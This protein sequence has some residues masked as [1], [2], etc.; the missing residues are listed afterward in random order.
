MSS[1][2]NEIVGEIELND[3]RLNDRLVTLVETFVEHPAASI[4]E[5]CGTWAA[6][7]AAYRFFD[8]EAVVPERIIEAMAQATAK[9][10][11]GVELVLAVQDTTSL[12]YTT[13]TDTADLGSL[14]HPQHRGLFAHSV[15]AVNARGGVPIGVV[16]QQIWARDPQ[17]IGKSAKRKELPIEA[18]E[19][20]RW[21]LGLR[22]SEERLGSKVA[23]LSVADRE[24]DVYELFALARQSCEA[25]GWFVPAMTA[26][27]KGMK[28]TCWRRSRPLRYVPPP[29]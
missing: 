21:L 27:W 29:R 23:V 28:G 26:S 12:D 1:W 10:C 25:T 24:A 5:A 16:S 6:T 15:L 19:S 13:H 14:E 7:E 18:K 22:E 8:N 9:R 11:R 2:A 4:P 3:D 20:A 17:T